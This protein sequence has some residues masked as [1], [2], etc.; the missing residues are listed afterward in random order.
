MKERNENEKIRL[1]LRNHF[2]E[3]H[4]KKNMKFYENLL[5]HLSTLS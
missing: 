1:I 2:H 4:C 5:N 3:I